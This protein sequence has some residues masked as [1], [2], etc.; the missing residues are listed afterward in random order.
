MCLDDFL[1]TTL[2]NATLTSPPF[3]VNDKTICVQLLVGL[4]AEC[5]AHIVLRD[6]MNH[7]VLANVTVKGLTKAV[8]GLPM[9]QSITIKKNSL[10]YRNYVIIQL[11]P[12]LNNSS[13]NPLWAIANVRQCPQ[14]GTHLVVFKYVLLFSKSL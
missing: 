9:W 13:F 3:Q 2:E 4:C 1:H 8:H 5:N 10:I 6:T 11:I 14:N 12:K 7:E